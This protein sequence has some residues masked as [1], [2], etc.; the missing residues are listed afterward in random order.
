MSWGNDWDFPDA[1]EKNF[2]N[3]FYGKVIPQV[4]ELLT[5]YGD[6][7]ELWCDCPLDMKP[8][9]S[10]VLRKVVKEL[11]PG[12]MINSRIGNNCHDFIGL[13]DNQILSNK[14]AYPVES[15]GTLNNT[16]GFKYDDHNWKST[17]QIISQL[18]ALAA[19]NANYLLNIG[20]MPTGEWTP[21]TDRI[22]AGLA[23]WI[24]D[25]KDAIHGTEPNPF[26]Q[27]LGFAECTTKEADLNLFLRNTPDTI[28][29]SGIKNKVVAANVPFSQTQ[30]GIT[31]SIPEELK[32]QFLPLVK[33]T[34]DGVPEINPAIVP[35]N[36]ELVLG[37]SIA[38]IHL[39]AQADSARQQV[40][41]DVAGM[42][43]DIQNRA[44]LDRDGTLCEWDSTD[45]YLEWNV[46]FPQGGEFQVSLI[47]KTRWSKDQ[48]W[49]GDS[50]V[51]QVLWNGQAI[52][53]KLNKDEELLDQ[54]SNK[55]RSVIGTLHMKPETAGVLTLKMLEN[56]TR[57]PGNLNL[58]VLELKKTASRD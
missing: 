16:W 6:I 50:K 22:F 20:P 8:E 9:F 17:E 46:A 4:T 37:M 11:Q 35:Q 15:P 41:V 33:L 21:E 47:S 55:F 25:K 10:Q 12:C 49:D 24:A 34:F 31:L 52:S 19:K 7:C 2:A 26:P 27:E 3:Y 56:T 54:Y 39:P 45:D 30:K 29:L 42:K 18:V 57:F 23:Q 5:N 36:G 13:G 51:F 44:R 14:L 53:A 48:P 43:H 32:K 40:L 1:S 38:R 28:Q 58:V